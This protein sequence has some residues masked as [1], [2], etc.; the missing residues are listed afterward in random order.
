MGPCPVP[1]DINIDDIDG[2]GKGSFA[3]TGLIRSSDYVV[4][5]ASNNAHRHHDREKEVY[6]RLGQHP[7]ILQYFGDVLIHS[8]ERTQRG[9][10][11]RHL[12]NGTLAETLSIRDPSPPTDA[13]RYIHSRNVIHGDLG[14]HNFLV[15]D[16]GSLALAD[17]GGSRIDNS[18]CLEFPP[19]RTGQLLWEDLD[20]DEIEACFIN[21]Q[22]PSFANVPD[23]LE[24]III[25][26]WTGKYV[27]ADHV[28]SD[29]GALGAFSIS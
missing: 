4:K 21:E 17:F 14:C 7:R 1:C 16:D 13:V 5:I 19:A 24:R 27:N 12:K 3:Q 18:D 15:K 6:Q 20:D 25:R 9:L 2:I 26:C 28:A 11:L 29:L 10:L 23:P 8:S 22:Y